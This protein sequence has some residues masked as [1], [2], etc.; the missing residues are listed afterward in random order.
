MKKLLVRIA[1]MVAALG[2]FLVLAPSAHAA[3]NGRMI[4]DSVFD[5]SSSM[6]AAD[7]QTFLN[8]FPNGCLKNYLDDMPS[9]NPVRAYF[10]YSGT[11]TAAQIIRRVADNYGINPRVLLTKLEQES[12]LVSGGGG[13]QLWRQASAIGFK[14]FDGANPRTT[15][16]RGSSIQTCVAT[17]ADMG[18]A[19]QLSKGAWLLKW[20]KERANGNLNWMVPDDA[21]STYG[22]PMTQGSKKRCASCATVY[23]DGYWNGVY[24]ESG[25]TA[26]LYNYT[27][28]LNQAFDEI[29][30]GWWGVGS[31]FGTPYRAAYTAQSD[32]PTILAGQTSVGYLEYKNTGNMP[33]YDDTTAASNNALPV[34]L[35]TTNPQNRRSDF[36]ATWPAGN[37]SNVVFT[38]V[39]KADG[40]A[41]TTNPHVVMPGELVGFQFTFTAPLT[42]GSGVYREYFQPIVEGTG[43]GAFPNVGTFLDVR[44]TTPSY[45]NQFFRQSNYAEIMPGQTSS[46]YIDFKN[47]SNVAWYDDTTAGA[48]NALPVHLATNAPINRQSPLGSAWPSRN[49]PGLNFSVVYEANG[50]TL[51]GNQHV[52]QPGQVV[53]F[54]FTFTAAANQAP[55]LY[56]EYLR[57]I[58]E[59]SADGALPDVSA[60]LEISVVAPR[61]SAQFVRQSNYADVNRG[62]TSAAYFDL[63]NDGNMPWYDDT[64]LNSGP[65]GTLPVHLA[66]SV[67]VNRQSV[68][69]ATWPARNRPVLSFAA[70]YEANGTT[71]AASQHIAQPG[72]IARFGFTFTVPAGQATGLYREYFRPVLEG[73]ADGAIPDLYTYLEIGVR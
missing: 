39:Y 12:S 57:P 29:W 38:I 35:A 44:V 51:A 19:R 32:Y 63:K 23:Y 66:T 26:S 55:G 4:D 14:C 7:I 73:S 64:S 18:V 13:C 5:N 10:D 54:A 43:D 33:W 48:N 27:P 3:T 11:G 58:V 42:M 40:S 61:Y 17:D 22:G 71:L 21:A 67:P 37:R 20:G 2:F 36:S 31:T 53:R 60:Y 34:H 49:R 16:F 45:G 52:A 24:L 62:Q 30:E 72:Q 70:V 56:R 47:T 9:S 8:G 41:Y 59:G 50:T 46:A 65:A 1:Q 6:S 15:T 28:Y 68:L 69:A 25:A